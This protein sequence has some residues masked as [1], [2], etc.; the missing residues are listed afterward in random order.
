MLILQGSQPVELVLKSTGALTHYLAQMPL[1]AFG[2]ICLGVPIG[3]YFFKKKR[4][5][6]YGIIEIIF[7]IF[8]GF[9]AA[10]KITE[11]IKTDSVAAWL[12]FFSALYVGSRGWQNAIDV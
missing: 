3:L 10:V 8:L 2:L 5:R 6:L 4:Q 1:F 7:A 11:P 12:A 9:V